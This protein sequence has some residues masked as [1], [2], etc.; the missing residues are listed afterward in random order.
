MNFELQ[1]TGLKNEFVVLVPLQHEDFER[2]YKVASDPLIWEQHPNKNRY[3][4]E[5]FETYFEGAMES[6]GAFLVMDAGTGEPIGSSRYCDHNSDKRTIEIGYTFLAKDHWGTVYNRALKTLMLD[7]AF[8]FVDSVIFHIGANNIRSQKAIE[9][10]GAKK[11][12]ETIM[13]YYGEKDVLNYT[14]RINK[15]D[16]EQ[17]KLTP[18]K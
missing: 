3:Q 1:P 12:N 5:V 13:K 11:I 16:W 10:L 15:E 4:R 9:K 17:I 14:Y 2:L 18:A 8:T 7:H 6:G